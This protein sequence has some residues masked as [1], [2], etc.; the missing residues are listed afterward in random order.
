[1]QVQARVWLFSGHG[2]TLSRSKTG[3][4]PECLKSG[5]VTTLR[6]CSGILC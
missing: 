2:K 6:H 4:R 3:L 5:A 1:M